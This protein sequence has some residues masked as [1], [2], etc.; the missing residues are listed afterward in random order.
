MA[1]LLPILKKNGGNSY[2]AAI[3]FNFLIH[4]TMI[5]RLFHLNFILYKFEHGLKFSDVKNGEIIYINPPH[6]CDK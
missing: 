5:K 4:K 6:S 2:I 1:G 3:L